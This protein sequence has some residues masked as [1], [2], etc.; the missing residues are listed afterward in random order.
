MEKWFTSRKI[1]SLQ[2][3]HDFVMYKINGT[4]ATGLRSA[5]NPSVVKTGIGYDCS[6]KI[7]KTVIR[8]PPSLL[9]TLCA[10]V[11]VIWSSFLG[12]LI[13]RKSRKHPE[14]AQANHM[15]QLPG[16]YRSRL[17]G[18]MGYDIFCKGAVMAEIVSGRSR[19]RSRGALTSTSLF[20][21]AQINL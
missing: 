20:F 11:D 7:N 2:K 14:C 18:K 17:L 3:L 13:M 1:I 10:W 19:G 6:C 15:G 9:G 5:L 4:M 8:V 12:L 16:S 21:W